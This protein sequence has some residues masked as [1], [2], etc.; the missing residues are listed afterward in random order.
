VSPARRRRLWQLGA[1]GLFVAIVAAVAII[2]FSAPTGVDL[3]DL[4]AQSK[5]V[6]RMFAGLEQRGVD[7]GSPRAPATLVEFADPQCPFCGTF[8]RDVLPTVVR[9]YVRDGR[10]RL[11]L[12]LL[13]ILGGDSERIARLAAAA[14]LQNRGWELT[15]L[16]YRNQGDENSGYATDSYLRRIAAATPGLDAPRAL[17]ATGSAAATRVLEQASSSASAQ[18]VDSTPTFLLEQRGKPPQEVR[19]SDPTADAFSAA[20]DPLLPPG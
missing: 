10:V 3:G 17:H 7:L 19:P 4:P 20:L 15:D 1:A 5:Q 14:S 2:V 13:T 18:G 9:R 11:R 16:A 12:E 8:A 6:K